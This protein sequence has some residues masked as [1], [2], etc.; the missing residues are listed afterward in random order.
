[1]LVLGDRNVFDSGKES[2]FEFVELTVPGTTGI[3]LT[4][5]T[6]YQGYQVPGT[7]TNRSE[8]GA[9]IAPTARFFGLSPPAG[10]CN[11]DRP[12]ESAGFLSMFLLLS[13]FKL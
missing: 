1:M 6:W 9:G 5:V 10:L 3:E 2:I 4:T 13:K 11:Y 7:S 12:L 8:E